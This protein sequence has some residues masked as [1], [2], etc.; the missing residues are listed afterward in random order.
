MS[1]EAYL[2]SDGYYLEKETEQ[3]NDRETVWNL[4]R[5]LDGKVHGS[6]TI[7]VWTYSPPSW[8]ISVF[9]A[10]RALSKIFNAPKP[11]SDEALEWIY[12]GFR[13][14]GTITEAE[15]S[16][17]LKNVN[18]P[19]TIMLDDGYFL[20]GPDSEAYPNGITMEDL[21]DLTLTNWE[22]GR[23]LSD[24]PI[25]SFA[26][27]LPSSTDLIRVQLFGFPVKTKETGYM[28]IAVEAVHPYELTD[29]TLSNWLLKLLRKRGVISEVN[30]G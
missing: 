11:M 28:V 9:G 7:A 16:K 1:N 26:R 8:Y 15:M 10:A 14:A 18:I 17:Q 4:M 22:I 3:S 29:G 23:L 5:L 12:N 2:L 13:S 6:V 21:D 24:E 30:H 20:Q 27:F 19:T 25:E